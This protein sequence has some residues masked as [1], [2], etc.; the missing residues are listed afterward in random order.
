MRLTSK[1]S[2]ILLFMISDQSARVAK[3]MGLKNLA[4]YGFHS[5][6]IVANEN[7]EISLKY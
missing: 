2:G 7:G 1:N 6:L 3:I 5:H 4:H